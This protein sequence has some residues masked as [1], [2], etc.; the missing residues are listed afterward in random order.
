VKI[1]HVKKEEE[2]G[3]AIACAAMITG[4]TYAEVRDQFENDFSVKPLS[5]NKIIRYISAHGFSTLEKRIGFYHTASFA[6]AEMYTPFADAHLM[7]YRPQ[8]DSKHGHAIVMDKTG[9]LFCPDEK[10]EE[11]LTTPWFVPRV[12]GFYR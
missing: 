10:P 6:Q 1:T 9:K 4:K 3:C 7:L 5:A 11:L 2:F 12:I 8:F